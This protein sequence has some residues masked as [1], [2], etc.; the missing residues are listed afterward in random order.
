MDVDCDGL[1]SQGLR[2][3]L[4]SLF[5]SVVTLGVLSVD[6]KRCETLRFPVRIFSLGRLPLKSAM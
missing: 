3:N 2:H 4:P 6:A 1:E 5:L